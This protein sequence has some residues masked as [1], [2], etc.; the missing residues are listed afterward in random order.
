VEAVAAGRRIFA[1]MRK[2]MAYVAAIHL[3]ITGMALLPA[4]FG[5]PVMLGPVHIVF[6]ELVINPACAIVFEREPPEPGLMG[7]PPRPPGSELFGPREIARALLAGAAAL[8]LLAPAYAM[9]VAWL[10]ERQARAFG[11]AAMVLCNL[12]LLLAQRAGRRGAAS[13]L[14]NGNRAFWI[15]AAAALAMLAAALYLPPMAG[16]FRFDAPPPALLGAAAALA[17][18]LVLLLEAA[19]LAPR[20]MGWRPR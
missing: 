17:A 2:A 8:A 19:R 14:G 18:V 4:L 12:A 20:I 1:N 16:L 9:A 11:F 3:P 10:P 15:V 6:L 7:Q 13:A 5:W